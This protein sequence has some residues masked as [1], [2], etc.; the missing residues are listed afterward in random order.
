MRNGEVYL[1]YYEN[2]L[3]QRRRS[4]RH[5]FQHPDPEIEKLAQKHYDEDPETKRLVDEILNK[6]EE[7]DWTGKD[8][9]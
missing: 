3:R 5:I 9:D 1:T 6:G 8:E 2:L 4:L 7:T